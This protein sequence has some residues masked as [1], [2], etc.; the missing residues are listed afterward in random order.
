MQ[1]CSNFEGWLCAM[2]IVFVHLFVI[3]ALCMKMKEERDVIDV[4]K[5]L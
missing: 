5:K 3:T 2:P 4:L 1:E